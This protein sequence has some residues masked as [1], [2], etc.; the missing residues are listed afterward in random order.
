MIIGNVVLKAIV[1]KAISNKNDE[2]LKHHKRKPVLGMPSSSASSRIFF[3]AMISFV[4]KSL[5]GLMRLSV[6]GTI[7]KAKCYSLESI[8]ILIF[9][10]S[11]GF[12]DDTICP[13]SDLLEL[14]V[15]FHFQEFLD[16]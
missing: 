3:S 11:P 2:C 9:S 6:S 8:G 1:L 4:I 16:R 10:C 14:L 5:V 7:R 15:T 13:F 12:I